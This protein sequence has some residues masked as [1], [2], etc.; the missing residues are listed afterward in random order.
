MEKRVV[1][2]LLLSVALVYAYQMMLFW[3][4]G[5]PPQRPAA[6]AQQ[7]AD[8][9]VADPAA[10]AAAEAADEEQPRSPPADVADAN[11]GEAEAQPALAAA[12]E[13][14]AEQQW[15]TLGSLERDGPYRMLVTLTNR[16]GTVSR[17]ELTDP[18]FRD[19][20]WR[21]GYLGHL[22]ATADP[23]G[24]GAVVRVVGPGTPADLAGIEVGDIITALD[25]TPIRGGVDLSAE[26][27]KR[28][29][30]ETVV[31]SVL[32]GGAKHNL[33]VQ[34]TRRPLE[35]IRPEGTDPLSFEMTLN[36]LDDL[37]LER[38]ALEL[39]GLN[40]RDG[41]WQ[42]AEANET[43]VTFRRQVQGLEINKTYRLEPQG[44]GPG[45]DL[46]F[47]V[48]I[49]NV[50]DRPHRVA[51]RLDG[52]TGLP[53]EGWWYAN[54]IGRDWGAIGLRDVAVGVWKENGHFEPKIVSNPTIVADPEPTPWRDESFA[55]IGVDAQY[56][57][58]AMIP[59]HGPGE[60]WHELAYPLLVGPVPPEKD[61]QRLTDVSFRLISKTEE[62]AP[63]ETTLDHSFTVFAGPKKPDVLAQYNL[64]ELVY[65]GWFGWVS[66]P[67]L[68]VLHFFHDYITF[69]NY[70]LAIIL[71][72][73]MVR[74]C[75]FPLS[76]KQALSA[77][78]MQQL[79]PEMKRIAEKYKNNLEQRSK[80]QQELF[81]KHNYNPLGGCLLMFIQLPIFIGLY[82]SLSVDVEL[83][84][85]PLISEAIRWCSNLAAP[86]M[87][88]DWS[89][90]MPLFVQS[91]LGPYFNI[92][93][94]VTVGLFLWQQKMFMPPPTDDQTRMQM[95]IM[96]YM[97]LFMG[98]LFFKVASGLCIYFIAS[99]IWG[100]AERKLLPKTI[101][102]QP[103]APAAEGKAEPQTPV[104]AR[105][106]TSGNGAAK[107][108]TK[109]RQRG[110]R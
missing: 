78:K 56:F 63:G 83:R 53:T 71:L 66:R 59:H 104:A 69:G 44:D 89:G 12:E 82:R 31:L 76:R 52:P 61:K 57:S 79:Q 102:S 70:G 100:I 27:A 34:L 28:D 109:R 95:K 41:N 15:L 75:M 105:P 33:S 91:W 42:V 73:V 67:M 46:K 72:T 98:I 20:E 17:I 80:A 8:I 62:V 43:S 11:A 18:K 35:V 84:Q 16:G 94:L 13:A 38:N 97:M 96:Q 110:K 48:A 21:S 29:P 88:F 60:V 37:E 49:N 54:K 3:W 23:D 50:G 19:L 10:A 55:Y 106:S 77:Q 26:L 36:Q 9:D 2:F 51:Y 92:L 86:D 101:P 65:Y 47:N 81:K 85:A 64:D 4:Q 68:R 39:A 22:Q 93:P 103:S 7:D 30:Q 58:V 108:S 32:R 5:P 90:F 6:V 87:L 45:Y 99:S 1:L 74:L 24:R 14:P 40:L 107:K 25:D